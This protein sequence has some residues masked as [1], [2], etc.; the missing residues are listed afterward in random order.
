MTS[1]LLSTCSGGIPSD[2]HLCPQCKCRLI[3]SHGI[4]WCWECAGRWI[5]EMYDE[6]P[7]RDRLRYFREL[8]KG[9]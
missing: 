5:Y 3:A 8:G 4:G 2:A 9:G 1:T 7:M 6:R